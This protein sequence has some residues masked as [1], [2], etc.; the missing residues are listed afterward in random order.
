MSNLTHIQA[1]MTYLI[2]GHEPWKCCM[3]IVDFEDPDATDNT[4]HF[5]QV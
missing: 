3:P 4:A 1:M 2:V 5:V